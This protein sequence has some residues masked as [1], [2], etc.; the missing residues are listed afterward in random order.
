MSIKINIHVVHYE[1][2]MLYIVY[3]YM[4]AH[5]V[6][7]HNQIT[8]KLIASLINLSSECIT[9]SVSNCAV[10]SNQYHVL[11]NNIKHKLSLYY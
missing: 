8:I 7:V 10:T 11:Q 9:L 4:C 5:A 6:H 1:T 2:Y 3:E